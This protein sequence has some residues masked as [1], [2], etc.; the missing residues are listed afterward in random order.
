VTPRAEQFVVTAQFSTARA[1]RLF[2][3]YFDTSIVGLELSYIPLLLH[4][5]MGLRAR[6]DAM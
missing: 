5:T 4:D 2:D 6:F 1:T 3:L